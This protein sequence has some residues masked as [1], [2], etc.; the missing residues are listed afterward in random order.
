VHLLGKVKNYGLEGSDSYQRG[1]L[2]ILCEGGRLMGG[3]KPTSGPWVG[4]IG[5]DIISLYHCKENGP[6]SSQ[7]CAR[8]KKKKRKGQGDS[9]RKTLLSSL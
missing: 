3:E 9:T 6:E 4:E 2:R 1:G 8:D 7:G 5:P